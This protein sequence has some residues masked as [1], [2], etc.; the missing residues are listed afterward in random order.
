LIRRL[1]TAQRG[2]EACAGLSA[3]V[4]LDYRRGSRR[5]SYSERVDISVGEMSEHRQDVLKA[6]LSG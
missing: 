6:V 1:S 2:I 5:Y 4:M 3:R